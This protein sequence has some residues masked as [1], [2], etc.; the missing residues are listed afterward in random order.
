[1]NLWTSCIQVDNLHARLFRSLGLTSIQRD[2]M[3][4]VWR[5]WRRRKRALDKQQA[6]AVAT[7]ESTANTFPLLYYELLVINACAEGVMPLA[8]C[9][10]AIPDA[11]LSNVDRASTVPAASEDDSNVDTGI[12]C[13]GYQ[14]VAMPSTAGQATP[15]PPLGPGATQRRPA[16]SPPSC[17]LPNHSQCFARNSS[18]PG[19]RG[20]QSSTSPQE[21]RADAA[22]GACAPQLHG[23]PFR[24][25]SP[26]RDGCETS[27][28]HSN[29]SNKAFEVAEKPFDPSAAS[30][31]VA[32]PGCAGQCAYTTTAINRALEDLGRLL[33]SD[34]RLYEDFIEV[35]LHPSEIIDAKQLMMISSEHLKLTC[36]PADTL[37]ICELAYLQMNRETLFD[38]VDDIAL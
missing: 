5:E 1:M 22:E 9:E 34:G 23:A 30:Q 36:P 13:L 6:T 16:H 20:A 24:V 14:S 32:W 35:R 25:N 11:A 18:C 10:E 29:D 27:L 31:S 21:E 12:Q 7:L 26:Q 28:C 33:Q 15:S 19:G 17:A 2:N 4:R 37:M 38:M 8:T 3:A